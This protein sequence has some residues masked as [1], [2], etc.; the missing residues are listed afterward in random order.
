[1]HYYRER[2]EINTHEDIQ[3]SF[4][5][6]DINEREFLDWMNK[7]KPEFE[8]VKYKKSYAYDFID[9]TGRTWELKTVSQHYPRVRLEKYS[10]GGGLT[11]WLNKGTD[12]YVRWDKDAGWA[13]FFNGH[14]LSKWIRE[15]SALFIM[16][17]GSRCVTA[18]HQLHTTP[19]FK[20]AFNFKTGKVL[21]ELPH[22][23]QP[24][25]IKNLLKCGKE[26]WKKLQSQ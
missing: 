7:Y 11:S 13:Y 19:G 3:Q 18:P 9:K 26:A 17:S 24:P 23:P 20:F 10:Q 12:I 2:S 22:G 6:N 25:D 21:Y 15:S 5:L 4:K 8:L 14:E 1:M 16:P